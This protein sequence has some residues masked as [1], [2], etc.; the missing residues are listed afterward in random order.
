LQITLMEEEHLETIIKLDQMVFQREEPRSLEN[1]L[2]LMRGDEKGCFVLMDGQELVGYSFSKTMGEEGYLGPLGIHPSIQGQGHGKKLIQRSLY[3]LQ[4]HCR[5]VGLEVRPEA[6]NNLGL[7]HK[8]GFHSTYPSLILKVPEK[9]PG[10]EGKANI[11][12]G[13][14]QDLE[15]LK[16]ELFQSALDDRKESV[17]E[18]IDNWTRK[19]L[20]E[21][22]YLKDLNLVI[23]GGGDIIV[24]LYN[25]E[26]VGFLTF[27]RSVFLYLWG[28]V[29]PHPIQD[30]IL[31]EML[32]LFRENHGP[33]EVLLEVNT[34][35]HNLV[36]F[37]LGEDFRIEKSVVRMLLEG[38]A[39][40]HLKKS[41]NMV[42]RAWHA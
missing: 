42:M 23:E 25:N 27:Y 26:P 14:N 9:I 22:S 5:V 20:E 19:E 2:G 24:A 39:G 10:P 16:V 4:S 11:G 31:K 12:V 21:V 29:K 32:I 35:F 38:F 1:L 15:N 40:E 7:Y 36:D 41:Q 3:Y 18:K 34:R 37:L 17:L 8:L 28:V 33:G 30:Q 6:G 13:V